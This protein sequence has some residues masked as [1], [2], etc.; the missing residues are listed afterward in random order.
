M[1]PIQVLFFLALS[2]SINA[3]VLFQPLITFSNQ[4][5]N[6]SLL[7]YHESASISILIQFL[8]ALNFL[9]FVLAMLL[10]FIRIGGL[11][12]GQQVAIPAVLIKHLMKAIFVMSFT[13]LLIDMCMIEEL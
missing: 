11:A 2:V 1:A 8:L 5:P 13:T 4:H 6:N 12:E 3:V 9:N 10:L 7:Q